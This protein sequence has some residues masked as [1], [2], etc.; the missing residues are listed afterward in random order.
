VGVN[1][2]EG[3]VAACAVPETVLEEDFGSEAW[4]LRKSLPAIRLIA[5]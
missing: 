1:N 5:I 4:W 2:I 3:S